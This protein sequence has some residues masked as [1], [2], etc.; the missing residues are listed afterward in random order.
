MEFV[1]KLRRKGCFRVTLRSLAGIVL[2]FG[3]WLGFVVRNSRVQRDAVSAIERAGGHVN[4]D[5]GPN[6]DVPSLRGKSRWPEWLK[7]LVGRDFFDS[8]TDVRLMGTNA[9]DAELT[10]IG[11]LPAVDSLVLSGQQMTNEGL[12]NIGRLRRM[13]GLI[14]EL[15]SVTNDG[16]AHFRGLA[17]LEVLVI[18][19]TP[20]TDDGL[21][22]LMGLTNLQR[23]LLLDTRVTGSGVRRL[24]EALPRLKVERYS[25]SSP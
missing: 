14:I 18:R 2:V 21:R 19:N 5:G 25:P 7:S 6:S 10:H 16:I 12:A 17:S 11:H 13:R 23:L 24:K 3:I 1:E 8:V 15:P 4:Y 22:N 9:S 20:V